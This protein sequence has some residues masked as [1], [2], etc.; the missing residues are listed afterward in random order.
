[1]IANKPQ[2]MGILNVT[3]D[4]FSDGGQFDSLDAAVEQAKRM[5]NEGA[6]IIDIGGESTRPPDLCFHTVSPSLASSA[7]SMFCSLSAAKTCPPAATGGVRSLPTCFVHA[8][9][10]SPERS[11]LE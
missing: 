2:I 11:A 1:M 3:P 7:Y 5:I 10:T 4:S 6:D 9:L 8:V